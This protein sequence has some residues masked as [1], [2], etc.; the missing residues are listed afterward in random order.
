MYDADRDLEIDE[1]EEVDAVDLKSEDYIEGYSAGYSDGR[2]K[3]DKLE[4]SVYDDFSKG[5]DAGYKDGKGHKSKQS[6]IV[7]D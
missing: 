2:N 3:S 6:F 4:P 7:L 5:Y 1:P